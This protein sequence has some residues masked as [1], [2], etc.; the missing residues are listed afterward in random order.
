MCFALYQFWEP[1]DPKTGAFVQLIIHLI[2]NDLT[3]IMALQAA[4]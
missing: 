4:F 3:Y 2:T 1:F